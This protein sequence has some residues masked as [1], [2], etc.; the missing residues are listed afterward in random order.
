MDQRTKEELKKFA[1]TGKV[2]WAEANEKEQK[3]LETSIRLSKLEKGVKQLRNGQWENNRRQI[4]INRNVNYYSLIYLHF[5]DNN[6]YVFL[7]NLY[8]GYVFSYQ[9]TRS[10]QSKVSFFSLHKFQ[11]NL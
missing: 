9:T 4:D 11:C 3:R 7:F 10:P 2:R 1:Q 5:Y 6:Y 8:I